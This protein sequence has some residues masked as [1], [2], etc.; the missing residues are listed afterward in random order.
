MIRMLISKDNRACSNAFDTLTEPP[1]LRKAL[2]VIQPS[3]SPS[4]HIPQDIPAI[5]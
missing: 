4:P 5:L 2:L 3:R 1:H